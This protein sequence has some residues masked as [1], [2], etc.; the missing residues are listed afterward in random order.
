V[1]GK[2]VKSI[3][4]WGGGKCDLKKRG[5]EIGNMQFLKSWQKNIERETHVHQG[6]RLQKKRK[7]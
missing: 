5:W 1:K 7:V 3:E 2:K 4:D 6:K